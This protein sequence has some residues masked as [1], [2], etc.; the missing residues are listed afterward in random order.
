[1]PTSVNSYGTRSITSIGSA[2]SRKSVKSIA[3]ST[4]TL[5]KPKWWQRRPI[6]KDAYFTDVQKGS[7]IAAIYSTV[8]SLPL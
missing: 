6:L 2:R 1:M 8:R 5:T 3:A 4:R 7:Y